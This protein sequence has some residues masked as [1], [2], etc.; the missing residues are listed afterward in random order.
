MDTVF[1]PGGIIVSRS[2]AEYVFG[3]I[4]EACPLTRHEEADHI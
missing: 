4:D 1:G 3:A 2:V